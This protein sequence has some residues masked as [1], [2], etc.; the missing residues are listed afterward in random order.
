MIPLKNLARKRFKSDVHGVQ[1]VLCVI[2]T[3]IVTMEYKKNMKLHFIYVL[4]QKFI[5]WFTFAWEFHQYCIQWLLKI[6]SYYTFQQFCDSM[7]H[8]VWLFVA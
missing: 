2:I 1:G 7:S 5:I 4:F 6:F 3:A 8:S